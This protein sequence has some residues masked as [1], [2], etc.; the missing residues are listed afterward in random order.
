MSSVSKMNIM[1]IPGV[2]DVK[3]KV[4][5]GW[6]AGAVVSVGIC[7]VGVGTGHGYVILSMVPFFPHTAI[8]QLPCPS[9]VL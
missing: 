9:V 7:I 2:V 5:G 4:V 8:I 1:H 3:T 6:L